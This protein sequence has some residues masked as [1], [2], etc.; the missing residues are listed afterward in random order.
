MTGF[1]WIENSLQIFY[2]ADKIGVAADHYH[3]DGVKI[4]FASKAPAQVRARINCGLELVA[5]GAQKTENPLTDF[6][7]DTQLC[8]DQHMDGDC[9]S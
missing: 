6:V 9:V 5:Q 4:P 2:A 7:R 3:I 1:P 8:F